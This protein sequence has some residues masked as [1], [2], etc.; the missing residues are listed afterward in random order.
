[1]SDWGP[2]ELANMD[3]AI[4]SATS[5]VNHYVSFYTVAVAAGMSTE[6]ALVASGEHILT[7][8]NA[9]VTAEEWAV[10]MAVAVR[11]IHDLKTELGTIRAG[12]AKPTPTDPDEIRALVASYVQTYQRLTV[13]A[14]PDDAWQAMVLL[15]AQ[16]KPGP[17]VTAMAIRA[18]HGYA[19]GNR[20]GP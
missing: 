20:V 1:M 5:E 2:G 9:E 10:E 3:Q 12:L 16:H 15:L 4:A 14:G 7:D 13:E 17:V 11:L 8:H 6:D 18:V 19:Y